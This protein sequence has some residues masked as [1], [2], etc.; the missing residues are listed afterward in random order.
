[1]QKEESNSD[2]LSG[3]AIEYKQSAEMARDS[4]DE[5]EEEQS[6]YGV[7][8]AEIAQTDSYSQQDP[9]QL[10]LRDGT[11]DEDYD[12][13]EVENDEEEDYIENAEEEIDNADLEVDDENEE[14]EDE[15]SQNEF[16]DKNK[17][18]EG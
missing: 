1:M 17:K 14:G 5:Y 13:E 4:E 2:Q 9:D 8:A 11:D 10:I 15:Y 7:S 12:D 18:A 16:E 3:D 6:A